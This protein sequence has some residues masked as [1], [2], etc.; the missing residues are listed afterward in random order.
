LTLTFANSAAGVPFVYPT[1]KNRTVG[2]SR[3]AGDFGFPVQLTE[4][5]AVTRIGVRLAARFCDRAVMT[6]P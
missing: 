4:S 5:I 1:Q 2:E 6:R 3:S